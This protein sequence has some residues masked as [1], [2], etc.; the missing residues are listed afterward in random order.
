M[1]Q[2]KDKKAGMAAVVFL[3]MMEREPQRAGGSKEEKSGLSCSSA[4]FLA[5][6]EY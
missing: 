4:F 3:L 6:K 2:I 5:V 1:G